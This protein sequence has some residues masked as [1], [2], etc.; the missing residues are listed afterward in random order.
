M[1]YKDKI[2]VVEAIL[3]LSADAVS[4]N[5]LKDLVGLSASDVDSAIKYLLNEY[6]E[7]NRGI[8]IVEVAGGY[9]M[10]SNPGYS[11]WLQKLKS[12]KNPAKLSI[13][14]LETLAIVAYK[15]PITKIEIE[16]IR[17][18]SSDQT[19][20]NLLDRRLIKII[21]RKDAPGKPLLFGTTKEFLEY[22]GLKDIS[23]LPVP[24]D[25]TKED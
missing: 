16:Q 8:L 21:G 17:R 15:Q 1:E 9:K 18:V 4:I 22:F 10:V 14:S 23:D 5:E 12:A 20:K 19:V 3:F 7:K 25:L 6:R 13:P 24:K 2:A 11:V